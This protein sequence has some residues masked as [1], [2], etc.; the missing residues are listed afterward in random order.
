MTLLD[1]TLHEDAILCGAD[2]ADSEDMAFKVTYENVTFS[3]V[4]LHKP[5]P[6]VT[7]NGPDGEIQIVG[8]SAIRQ[9]S[10]ALAT[11]LNLAERAVG[12]SDRRA[13]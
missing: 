5:F 10:K 13:A 4:K 7:L 6:Q 12:Q 8:V 2:C 1:T 11:A 9:F 3:W